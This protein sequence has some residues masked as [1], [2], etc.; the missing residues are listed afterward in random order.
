MLAVDPGV[1]S[2]WAVFDGEVLTSCGVSDGTSGGPKALRLDRL[3][4]EDQVVD[5]RTPNPASIVKLAQNAGAWDV[6][7]RTRYGAST[8]EWV[9]PER[10]KGQMAKAP[11]HR[12]IWRRLEVIEQH[13]VAEATNTP[14]ALLFAALFDGGSV[15][16]ACLAASRRH[17]LLDAVGI[18]LW[19]VGRGFR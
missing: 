7:G 17:N 15:P 19:A 14:M 4:V 6:I 9:R 3:V 18:G 8:A 5:R 12:A 11:C 1:C 16:R 2:G 13:A 10:W